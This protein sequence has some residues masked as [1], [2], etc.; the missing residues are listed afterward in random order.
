MNL[1]R[2]LILSPWFVVDELI[3]STTNFQVTAAALSFVTLTSGTNTKI[4]FY[5]I[6]Q[7]G[8]GGKK[9]MQRLHLDK[10]Y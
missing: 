7:L 2:I 4:I 9:F 6:R 3:F 5:R 1:L 8:K 10:L